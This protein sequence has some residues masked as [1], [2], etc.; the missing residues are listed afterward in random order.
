MA[1]PNYLSE[2]Q[3]NTRGTSKTFSL[4]LRAIEFT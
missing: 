3:K 1:F 2:K 4:I